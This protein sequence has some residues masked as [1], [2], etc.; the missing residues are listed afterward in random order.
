VS[1][2]TRVSCPACY[3]PVLTPSRLSVRSE[4]FPFLATSFLALL[5]GYVLS[6]CA[7]LPD[8]VANQC[9][10]G[11]VEPP[12]DCDS[13]AP[14]P[15]L[16][17]LPKGAA[18]ECHVDCRRRSD[19]TRLPCPSGWGC[20]AQDICR[21]PSGHFTSSPTFK[22]GGAVSLLA[23][24]FDGD[25][26]SDV[27]SLE[28]IDAIGRTR[29][30]F[31]YFDQSASPVETRTFPKQVASP[32]IADLSGDGLSDIV[33]A[34]SNI[35][36]L[37]GQPDR[38]LLPEAFSSFRFPGTH[39]RLLAIYDVPIQ[40]NSPVMILGTLDGVSGLFA[41]D[42]NGFLTDHAPLPSAQEDLA[43]EPV[44][45]NVIEDPESSPCWEMVAA[46]RGATTF[47]LSDLCRR[48]PGTGQ[49]TYRPMAIQSTVTLQP[50]AP[51]DAAPQIADIDG[52][53]HLD[54]FV[55]AGGLMYVAYGDGIGLSPARPFELMV[56]NPEDVSID[57]PF[58]TPLAAG[59]FTGDGVA[60]FVFGD[61]L[62][63]SLPGPAASLPRYAAMHPN[64]AA[65]WTEARIADFN[66]NGKLDVVAASS[67]RLGL[68]FFNGAGTENLTTFSVPTTAPVAFLI[69][70]DFDGDLLNDVAYVE[71]ASSEQDRDAVRIA[72]GNPSGPPNAPVTVARVKHVEQLDFLPQSGTGNI[73][74]ASSDVV[75]GVQTGVVAVFASSGDRI[76]YAP[77]TL[78]NFT[79]APIGQ[80]FAVTLTAGAFTGAGHRDVMSMAVGNDAG[81]LQIWLIPSIE[82]LDAATV[83]FAAG[84]DPRL[85]PVSG[86]GRP[87]GANVV[88]ASADLD[89]DG[90]D[91]SIWAISADNGKRCGLF[92]AGVAT[93]PVPVLLPR[94]TLFID[95]PC[96]AAQIGPLD[97]DGDGAIDI[98]LLTGGPGLPN[99]KLMVLWNDGK[100]GFSSTARTVL[101]NAG[102]SPEQF[103]VLPGTPMR[104]LGFAYVTAT[105]AVLVSAADLPR[106]FGTPLGLGA[107][108]NGS[109][110]VAADVNG[111][112]VLDLVLAAS[113]DVSVLQAELARP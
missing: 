73:T 9:G 32:S 97:V 25:G 62:L 61:H 15:G 2:R 29:M 110:I 87:T 46:G 104:A 55:G 107:L 94:A 31:H 47:S 102:D 23:G 27:V 13:F 37:I 77:L 51:I 82:S 60:D 41:P 98:A 40:G 70:G 65:R 75:A 22:V 76:P 16:S 52:D 7:G 8:V 21:K 6:G 103:T 78:V 28:S 11:V 83:R 43:G 30:R 58:P 24:D 89:G 56:A 14:A 10:N 108:R 105:G 4:V 86:Q 35:G 67:G 96:P 100:G 17:C 90:R 33:F 71:A 112:G 49:V 44:L 3:G 50:A 19:G 91:E 59:D 53:G 34:D 20:D 63:V 42:D 92:L 48:D 81:D 1:A 106:Q 68:D 80:S 99:R 101:N 66:G 57:L 93:D 111:D 36:V 88:A 95:E 109:G 79:E 45:A 85:Q 18:G 54:V 64:R 74:V 38:S 72:F 26:L 69:V 5:S 113:G 84:L 39:V 12:E